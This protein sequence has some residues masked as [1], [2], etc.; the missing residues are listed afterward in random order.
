MH[1]HMSVKHVFGLCWCCLAVKPVISVLITILITDQLPK[2]T[3]VAP[4]H[5]YFLHVCESLLDWSFLQLK[6]SVDHSL[7]S[8]YVHNNCHFTEPLC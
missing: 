6:N 5:T 7:P 3:S 4:N 2:L 8:A 1:G